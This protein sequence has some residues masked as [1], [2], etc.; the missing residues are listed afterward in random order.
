MSRTSSEVIKL[1]F[2]R[3]NIRRRIATEIIESLQEIILLSQS[4]NFDNLPLELA[5]AD[6]KLSSHLAILDSPLYKSSGTS[7]TLAN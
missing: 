4:I 7:E 2:I 1:Q 3:R 5:H 6:H